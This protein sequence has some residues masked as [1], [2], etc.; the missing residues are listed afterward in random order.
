MGRPDTPEI[1]TGRAGLKFKHYGPFRAWAGPGGP[2]VHLYARV[3]WVS[4][5]PSVVAWSHWLVGPGRQK[6]RLQVRS[7]LTRSSATT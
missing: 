4:C 1:Q 3:T 7:D 5:L 2:N 6:V